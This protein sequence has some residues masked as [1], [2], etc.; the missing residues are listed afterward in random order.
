[1]IDPT[2]TELCAKAWQASDLSSCKPLGFDLVGWAAILA[3]LGP[4]T[5]FVVRAVFRKRARA[6]GDYRIKGSVWRSKFKQL[7][8]AIRPMMDENGRIF[9]EFGPNSGAGGPPREVRQNLGVW[10]EMMPTIADN[11]ARIRNLINAN[12]DAIPVRYDGD[13]ERW[14]NHIDAFEAHVQ[15]PLADYRHHQFPQQIVEIVHRNA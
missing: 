14:I 4:A 1:M 7:C 10:R 9:R 2:L 12:R 15:D 3:A 5:F 8:R 11:N 6:A 13:F